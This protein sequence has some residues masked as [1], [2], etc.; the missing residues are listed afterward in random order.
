MQQLADRLKVV[1]KFVP[2][3]TPWINGTVERVNRDILQVLRVMLMELNLDTRN[4]PYLLPLIQANLNHSAVASLGGHA[5]I[6]LFTGLPAPSL[7]DTVVA[8]VGGVTRT[9]SVDM[10]AAASHLEQLRQHLAEMHSK[11]I[12]RKEQRRAYELLKAKGQTCNFEVGD[13]VLWSRVDKRMR[14]SKLLV[15]WVGP[16]RVTEAL[17]H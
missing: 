16:F 3:Y 9:L 5:P 17:S 14:G 15:R 11:V 1:Q 10:S 8:P 7:L 2:V 4:W 6:E 13:F 12:A